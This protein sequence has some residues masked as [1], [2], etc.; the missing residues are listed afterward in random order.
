M[1]RNSMIGMM[2]LL[3]FATPL[4][5]AADDTPSSPSKPTTKVWSKVRTDARQA[6]ND[7]T[8]IKGYQPVLDITQEHGFTTQAAQMLWDHCKVQALVLGTTGAY[9]GYKLQK[10][11][12]I[13]MGIF[14]ALY[15][16]RL[17]LDRYC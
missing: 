1:K 6:L 17:G 13:P 3:L 2:A 12:L 5:G 9:L 7:I 10:A 15:C 4:C 8:T 11:A 16:L 14:A